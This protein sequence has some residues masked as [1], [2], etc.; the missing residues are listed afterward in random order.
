MKSYTCRTTVYLNGGESIVV[1]SFSSNERDKVIQMMKGHL[2]T[3][4]YMQGFKIDAT[5]GTI[6]LKN[7]DNSSSIDYDEKDFNDL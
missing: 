3:V 2:I 5:V 7:N 1:T 6:T 4:K